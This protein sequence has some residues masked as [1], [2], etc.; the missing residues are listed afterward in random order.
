MIDC[1]SATF[2]AVRTTCPFDAINTSSTSRKLCSSSTTR[3][4]PIRYSTRNID[5]PGDD[6]HV[7]RATI[8]LQNDRPLFRQGDDHLRTVLDLAFDEDPA[9]VRGDD[10]VG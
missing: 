9:A 5:R 7:V 6:V 1:A 8:V 4:R 10:G 2:F 3:T